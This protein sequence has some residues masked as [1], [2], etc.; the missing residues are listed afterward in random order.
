MQPISLYVP[1]SVL[2]GNTTLRHP[3]VELALPRGKLSAVRLPIWAHSHFRSCISWISIYIQPAGAGSLYN[4]IY[5]SFKVAGL[6]NIPIPMATNNW[7]EYRGEETIWRNNRL[8]SIAMNM[9]V[10][11]I[12]YP[13]IPLRPADFAHRS[14]N[15]SPYNISTSS[16]IYIGCVALH[17]LNC[18][19]LWVPE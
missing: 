8:I 1:K 2:N 5:G 6:E 12:I 18:Q 16:C 11:T 3:G 14:V 7:S 17:C 10:T 9:L 19:A 15:I 4:L 13:L